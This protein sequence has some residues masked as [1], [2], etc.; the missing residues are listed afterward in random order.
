MGE[1]EIR[2]ARDEREARAF[3]R[4]ALRDVTALERMVEQGRFETSVRRLGVEQEMYLVDSDCRPAPRITELLETLRDPRFTT[5][6]ARFNLEANLV[7]HR[8]EGDVFAS[9][10]AELRQT[11]ELAERAAEPL[12]VRILLTGILPTLREEDLGL[13]NMTPEPRYRQLNNAVFKSRGAMTVSIDG[14]EQYEG[15]YDSVV[16]EGA[17]TSLQLHLQVD[18][19]EGAR[20]YNLA[21]LITAPLLAAA[22]NSPVL[23]GRRLWHETRIAVFERA[24]DDRTASQLSRGSL[25]RVTFG[26]SWVRDS[27]VEVF[28]DNLSRF[29]VL[30]TRDLPEDSL[31][32]LE[33]GAVPPLS[34]LTLHNGTVWRWNR[35]CYGLTDGQPHLR[36]ECRVLPSGPTVLDEVANAAL[37]CGLMTG[38]ADTSGEIARR[39]PF[40][41][42]RANFLRAARDG[43]AAELRWL[44]DRRVR[45]RELL[46]EELIPAA[47]TGLAGCGIPPEQVERYLGTVE[48]RVW[49]GRTGSRWLLEALA[50][51]ADREPHVV[52]HDAVNEMLARQHSGEPVH[53]WD[54]ELPQTSSA[55]GGP[56]VGHIMTRGLFTVRPDDVID[57]ATSV[58]EWKHVR[59]VPVE[60]ESGELLGVV[61]ARELLNVHERWPEHGAAEP[62]PVAAVMRSDFVQ[63]APDTPLGEAAR[64]MLE[65]D[66][67]CLLVI[68]GGKL[69]GMVTERDVVRVTSRLLG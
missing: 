23:L 69:V 33:R 28:R 17:N 24:L 20:L 2:E 40:A 32:C 52:S 66:C 46:L 51:N 39:L 15:S 11:V 26:D 34:A 10:E 21:Q 4:A 3:T 54:P 61:T 35:P 43:L 44:D 13:G 49:S 27:L 50:A 9:M 14:I 12:G 59:H 48:E 18:P 62:V 68:D 16:L 63:V 1:L 19:A 37:F 6:L 42:A 47:R 25:T 53:L 5:E 60:S 55:Q 30:L 36:I 58:M 7:P 41:D 22:T 45:A 31:A 8:L 57:L 29:P 65:S 67:G 64:Q 38:L 56:T